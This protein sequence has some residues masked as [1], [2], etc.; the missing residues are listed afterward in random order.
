M[1]PAPLNIYFFWGDAVRIVRKRSHILNHERAIPHAYDCD[2]EVCITEENQ[3]TLEE[4]RQRTLI[5]KR[6]RSGYDHR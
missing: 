6:R 1:N 4:I 3:K 5:L 2:Y